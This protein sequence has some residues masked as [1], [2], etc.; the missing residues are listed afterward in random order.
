[1]FKKIFLKSKQNVFLKFLNL[2]FCE[3]SLINDDF[4]DCF[5]VSQIDRY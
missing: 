3:M 5:E 4:K 1:M 2:K